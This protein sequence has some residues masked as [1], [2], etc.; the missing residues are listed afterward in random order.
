MIDDVVASLAADLVGGDVLSALPLIDRL[1]EIGD[2]RWWRVADHLIE[3][4]KKFD[5]RI[6]VDSIGWSEQ[7]DSA[8]RRTW[9]EFCSIIEF[10]FR[11]ELAGVPTLDQVRELAAAIDTATIPPEPELKE[12]DHGEDGDVMQGQATLNTTSVAAALP[13]QNAAALTV[14]REIAATRGL[15]DDVDEGRNQ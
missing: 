1:Y 15:F 7:R 11:V 12:D 9:G 14:A 8:R 10:G 4:R 6:A 5:R 3:M 13:N 2:E